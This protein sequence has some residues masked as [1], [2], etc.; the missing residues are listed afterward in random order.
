[1]EIAC[2]GQLLFLDFVQQN[3]NRKSGAATCS[4]YDDCF[5]KSQTLHLFSASHIKL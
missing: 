1:M 4:K 3:R 2:C 5:Y